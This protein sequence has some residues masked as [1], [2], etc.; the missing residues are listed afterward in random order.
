MDFISRLEMSHTRNNGFK[1]H[2]LTEPQET[3]DGEILSEKGKLG[4][5]SGGK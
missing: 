2:S 4:E 5:L 3:A 1:G